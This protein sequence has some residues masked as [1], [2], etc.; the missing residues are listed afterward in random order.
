[1]LELPKA[2]GNIHQWNEDQGQYFS[3]KAI[4]QNRE[5]DKRN[6]L[7]FREDEGRENV[8]DVVEMG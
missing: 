3:S 5:R 2:S 1:M 6:L 4:H 8:S 7:S